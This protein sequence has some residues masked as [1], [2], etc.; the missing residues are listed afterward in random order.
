MQ[1]NDQPAGGQNIAAMVQTLRERSPRILSD[2]ARVVAALA[3]M[4]ELWERL[5][6]SDW[7]PPEGSSF[8]W[9]QVRLSLAALVPG[10]KTAGEWR[11]RAATGDDLSPPTPLPCGAREGGE[12]GA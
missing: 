10:L 8:P 3:R 5:L 12:S 11:E 1:Q 4:G 2:P 6:A 9:A 7:T